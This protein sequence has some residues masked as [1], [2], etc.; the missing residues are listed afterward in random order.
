[1]RF[2][3]LGS[4]SED[5]DKEENLEAMDFEIKFPNEKENFLIVYYDI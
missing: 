4:S 1:M 3:Q 5:S 2:T